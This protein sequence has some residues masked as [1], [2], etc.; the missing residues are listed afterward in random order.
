[1]LLFNHSS[2]MDALVLAAA[3]PGEPAFVAKKELAPQLFAG[4]FLRKL[5]TLFVERFD[6]EASLAD[7]EKLT[8]VAREGR[9]LVFFPEG[10]F[11]RRPGLTRF[12]LGAFKIAAE[13][14]LPVVPGV[15]RGTRSML[16]ANQWFPRH[17]SVSVDIGAPI[18]PDGTDFS[19]VVHLRDRAREAILSRCGEPDIDEMVKPSLRNIEA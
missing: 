17:S 18:A 6:A 10:T 3:L 15:I 14:G 4:P 16:R 9:P 13:A 11:T 8:G 5:G 12:Y 2:Y 1:M 7:A 19:A